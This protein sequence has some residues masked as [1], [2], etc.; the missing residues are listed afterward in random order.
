MKHTKILLLALMFT[1]AAL[2]AGCGSDSG[3]SVGTAP[4]TP[5]PANSAQYVGDVNCINC[6]ADQ[7][8]EWLKAH[9]NLD[10]ATLAHNPSYPLPDESC[11]ACHDR[12]SLTDPNAEG[13]GWSLIGSSGPARPVVSCEACHGG[14]SF[15]YGMGPLPRPIPGVETCVTC[16]NSDVP[17]S[18]YPNHKS[19]DIAAYYYE[20]KHAIGAAM[21]TRDSI[22]ARCAM[23]HTDE[24]FIKYSRAHSYDGDNE[25]NNMTYDKLGTAFA[26][27]PA[28]S[29]DD[30]SPISCRTCHDPHSGELRAPETTNFSAQFNLCTSCHQVFVKY[31]PGGFT[32][33]VSGVVSDYFLDPAHYGGA[34]FNWATATE[35]EKQKLEYHH[36]VVNQYGQ[37]SHI[38]SDTHFAGYFPQKNTDGTVT[39]VLKSGY[40]SVGLD[41]SAANSCT[42]CHDPHQAKR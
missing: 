31:E 34:G 32:H 20:S 10:R 23:C 28:Y 25:R 9:G 13:K 27:R 1:I 8:R 24:G 33:P 16:H 19:S 12:S 14:G 6:H 15:H 2:L 3:T 29:P 11:A 36:P 35:A 26:N 5:D 42:A 30:V 17:A 41:P 37:P 21:S 4:G 40:Y 7:T 22:P 39:Q 38:I 18:T